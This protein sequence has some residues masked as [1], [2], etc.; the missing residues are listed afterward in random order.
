MVEPES[1]QSSMSSGPTSRLDSLES[2]RSQ[3]NSRDEMKS[4]SAAKTL[5]L[6]DRLKCPTR[7]VL[8]QTREVHCNPPPRGKKRST[9]QQK[10]S[11]PDVPPSKRVSEYPGELLTVSAGQLFYYFRWHLS[12]FSLS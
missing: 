2:G 8:S 5:S 3:E 1:S 9:G 12:G 10:V 11:D 4:D 6:L 7:S